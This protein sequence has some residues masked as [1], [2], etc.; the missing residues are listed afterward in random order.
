MDPTGA[1]LLRAV[2]FQPDDNV[3]RLVLADWLEENGRVDWAKFIR[4][5][6]LRQEPD[7]DVYPEYGF[8]APGRSNGSR[9]FRYPQFFMELPDRWWDWWQRGGGRYKNW[10]WT[11]EHTDP[12]F[13][14][15]VSRGFVSTVECPLGDWLGERC[16]TCA[17]TGIGANP[18][19]AEYIE[20]PGG[21]PHCSTDYRDGIGYVNGSMV[22][23][24]QQPVEK[25]RITDRLPRR[26]DGA[27]FRWY[28]SRNSLIGPIFD[29]L[30]RA[31]ASNW[32]SPGDAMPRVDY[33]TEKAASEAMGLACLNLARKRAKLPLLE[34]K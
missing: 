24:A 30:P 5:H 1:A 7:G 22:V 15:T 11:R 8:G 12:N 14:V 3:P 29:L 23:A 26:I 19:V 18:E 10:V 34:L 28:R 20:M 32:T 4:A 27:I 31:K 2:L 17:G 33:W 25:L 16:T 9:A 6:T 13:K 21:C